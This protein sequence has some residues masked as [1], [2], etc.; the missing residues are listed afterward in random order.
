MAAA[1][2]CGKDGMEVFR[3]SNETGYIFYVYRQKSDIKFYIPG[4]NI[5]YPDKES[6]IKRFFIDGI[7]FEVLSVDFSDFLKTEKKLTDIEILN[8]HAK[9]EQDYLIS[10]PSPL[11]KIISLGSRTKHDPEDQQDMTFNLWQ[12][13]NP[14]DPDGPSQYFLSTVAESEV[15][16]ISAITNG[17]N[18]KAQVMDAIQHYSGSLQEIRNIKRCPKNL[19]QPTKNK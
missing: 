17:K 14:K 7:L 1:L 2:P 18:D 6:G 5:S 11:K 15:F 4:K 10:T 3:D 9:Y 8:E 13:I 16:Y 19:T 12:A